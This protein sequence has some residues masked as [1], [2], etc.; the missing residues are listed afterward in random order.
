[1]GRILALDYGIKRTGVAVTD[2]LQIIATPLDTVDTKTLLDFLKRYC[3]EEA[4]ETIVIGMPKDLQN[5]DTHATV[6]V[7]KVI[8]S[9]EHVLPAIPIVQVDER[10]TSKMAFD[11]MLAAGVKKKDRRNKANVDKLSATIILQSFLDQNR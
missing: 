1:M 6:P 4:V 3:V 9:L 2:P 5:R 8:Q 10:F 11:T 7:K